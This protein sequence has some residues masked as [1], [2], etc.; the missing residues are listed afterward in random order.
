MERFLNKSENYPLKQLNILLVK[1]KVSR[2]ILTLFFY[3]KF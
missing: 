2:S 1:N 3:K